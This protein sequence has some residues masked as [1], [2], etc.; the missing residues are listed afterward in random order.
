M[1]VVNFDIETALLLRE[2]IMISGMLTNS[3]V[4]FNLNNH[5]LEAL[6]KVDRLYFQ[7][8]LGVPHTVPQPAI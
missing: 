7:K 8:L 2:A 3:E 6:E 1:R 4:W 5:D